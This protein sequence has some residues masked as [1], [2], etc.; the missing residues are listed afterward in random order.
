MEVIYSKPF[1]KALARLRPREIASIEE[2]VTRYKNNRADPSLHDHPLK[3]KMKFLRA[4][5]ASHDLR[6]I[7]REEG[8]FITIILLDAGSH[9]QVY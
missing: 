9:N 3:G 7:Y 4:F 2:A 5:S 8:G 6:V 1:R